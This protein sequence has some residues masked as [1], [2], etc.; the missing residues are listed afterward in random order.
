MNVVE[1]EIFVVITVLIGT[2]WISVPR[3]ILV[4]L[5]IPDWYVSFN[6]LASGFCCCCVQGVRR[7]PY[8]QDPVHYSQEVTVSRWLRLHLSFLIEVSCFCDLRNIPRSKNLT[9][10]IVH[11]TKP[12]MLWPLG[13]RSNLTFT[14]IYDR[15]FFIT[16]VNFHIFITHLFGYR[17]PNPWF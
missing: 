12:I 9:L 6:T 4:D 8:T 15:S 17:H 1:I 13:K 2:E 11:S 14:S 5:I 3:P 10:L 7:I 16:E